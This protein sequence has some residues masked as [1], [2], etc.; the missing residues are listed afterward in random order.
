MMAVS[1]ATFY[2]SAEVV[3]YDSLRVLRTFF[4]CRIFLAAPMKSDKITYEYSITWG[5]YLPQP[6]SNFELLLPMKRFVPVL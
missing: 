4:L 1:A 2:M 5:I 6:V 3:L